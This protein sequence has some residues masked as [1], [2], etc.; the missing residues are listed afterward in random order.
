MASI[1]P[2]NAFSKGHTGIIRLAQDAAATGP[3]I[4]FPNFSYA[5][6]V[7]E[8]NDYPLEID[9]S[10]Q[11]HDRVLGFVLGRLGLRGPV[12]LDRGFDV[13]LN[14]AFGPHVANGKLY[15]FIMTAIR[16]SQNA[17]LNYNGVWMDS[18]TLEGRFGTGGNVLM[19]G[20]SANGMVADPKN[21]FASSA[22]PPATAEGTPGVGLSSFAQAS[23]TNGA[24]TTP[25]VYDGVRAFQVVFRN[26]LSPD[27][28]AHASAPAGSRI[29]AGCTPSPFTGNVTLTQLLTPS[30]PLP[31]GGASLPLTLKIPSGDGSK[32]L[33]LDL[34]CSY[35]GEAESL[36][37]NDYNS[38]SYR[39]TLL[40]TAANGTQTANYQFAAA[41]A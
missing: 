21:A 4:A 37:P 41:V 24:A 25:V 35:D 13:F 28:A 38:R 36:V 31:M 33:T 18:L 2:L 16:A 7:D 9:S 12:K 10:S 32:T 20:S 8:G 29:I 6:D 19:L 34:S 1:F 22:L 23:V 15:P 40:G 11:Y 5:L 17:P 30:N 27:P 14:N 39:Y 3:T 26:N